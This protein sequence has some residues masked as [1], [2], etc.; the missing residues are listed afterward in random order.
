MYASQDQIYMYMCL[1]WFHNDWQGFASWEKKLMCRC[2]RMRQDNDCRND[3]AAVVYLQCS[4]VS[5]A[6]CKVFS[7]RI[8]SAIQCQL[9]GAGVSGIHYLSPTVDKYT[10]T[11]NKSRATRCPDKRHKAKESNWI[12]LP[13]TAAA[14]QQFAKLGSQLQMHPVWHYTYVCVCE[15]VYVCVCV[16]INGS[17]Y[18]Q[19]F[20]FPSLFWGLPM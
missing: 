1:L 15:L 10:D 9:K 20:F 6:P 2:S 14:A 8:L 4:R 3:P 17:V 13:L 11:Q 12:L 5:C 16:Y 7:P 19:L 18:K